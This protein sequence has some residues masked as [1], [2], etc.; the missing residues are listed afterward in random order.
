MTPEVVDSAMRLMPQHL[1]LLAVIGQPDLAKAASRDPENAEAMF[2]AAAAQEVMHRRELVLARLREHGA[3][4]LD[5][6]S[7]VLSSTL[8]AAYLDVKLRNQL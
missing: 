5:V 3:L 4:A 6:D 8:I 7:A 2:Q 1:V